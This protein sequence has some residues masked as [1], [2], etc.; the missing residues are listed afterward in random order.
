M[1]KYLV[2]GRW[3]PVCNAGVAGPCHRG[4]SVEVCPAVYYVFWLVNM[5]GEGGMCE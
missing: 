5:G 4:L 3:W 1:I 2:S